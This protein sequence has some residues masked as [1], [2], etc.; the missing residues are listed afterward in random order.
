VSDYVEV[1]AV[2]IDL[3]AYNACLIYTVAITVVLFEL[4]LCFVITKQKGLNAL[5]FGAMHAFHNMLAVVFTCVACCISYR[6][7]VY[8]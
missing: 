5:K 1:W 4:K 8:L 3:H 6:T 2:F 7:D